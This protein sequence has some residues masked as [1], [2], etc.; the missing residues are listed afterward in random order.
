MSRKNRTRGA[1]KGEARAYA[2]KASEFLEP[3]RADLDGG[4]RNAASL[5]AIHAGI[6][7]ADGVLAHCAGLL[8]MK[9][10]VEYSQR[11]VSET[12]ARTLVDQS[13]RFVAWANRA[14][15][16]SPSPRRPR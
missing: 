14:I 9:N 15:R 4:R 6:S 2:R 7:A 12:R 8:S 5:S 13:E 11:A 16:E 1:Q 10:E 3:A